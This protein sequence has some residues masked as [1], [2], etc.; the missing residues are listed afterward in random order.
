MSLGDDRVV[1][2]AEDL[3]DPVG[4]CFDDQI[5]LLVGQLASPR[6]IS[7]VLESQDLAQAVCSR[8][9]QQIALF[10]RQIIAARQLHVV[11]EPEGVSNLG[12]PGVLESLA[13][14]LGKVNGSVRAASSDPMIRISRR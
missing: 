1:R 4:T 13:L 3:T 9:G 2:Q 10:V 7:V 5:T 12:L 8:L 6:Q 11:L 14:L